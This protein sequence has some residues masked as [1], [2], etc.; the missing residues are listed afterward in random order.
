MSSRSTSST[1]AKVDNEKLQRHLLDNYISEIRVKL[2]NV[3][4]MLTNIIIRDM[5]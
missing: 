3:N 5:K 1:T 2:K 4:I